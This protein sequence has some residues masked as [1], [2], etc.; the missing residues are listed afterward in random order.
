MKKIFLL[1]TALFLLV[2]CGKG[3]K[4]AKDSNN[5]AATEKSADATADDE[6]MKLGQLKFIENKGW[7]T[8]LPKFG[9]KLD[10]KEVTQDYEYDD[11]LE[12]F[13]TY[14]YSRNINGKKVTLTY[15]E[16]GDGSYTEYDAVMVIEDPEELSEFIRDV[17]SLGKQDTSMNP[18]NIY[19]D[20]T[21][22]HWISYDGNEIYFEREH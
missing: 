9:F 20:N 17:L 7:S 18:H 8:V 19:F 6:E 21:N 10:N 1:A 15:T 14:N 3:A 16:W 13:T 12:T 5:S 11:Q 2:S 22:F 4:D